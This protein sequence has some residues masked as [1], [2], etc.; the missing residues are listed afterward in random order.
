[1]VIAITIPIENRSGKIA[2]RFSD[3][4]RS[5]TSG[6]E[7]DPGSH[8]KFDPRLK[9]R[10]ERESTDGITN[11]DPFFVQK[12]DR[13]FQIKIGSRLYNFNRDHDRDQKPHPDQS[14]LDL[15]IFIRL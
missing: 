4:N 15:K 13:D 9:T 8:F 11:R 6:S 10:Y 1:M 3:R 12:S 5:A 14:N 2:D 7:S